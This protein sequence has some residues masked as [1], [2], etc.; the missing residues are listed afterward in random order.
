MKRKI[1]FRAIGIF[2]LIISI[3]VSSVLIFEFASQDRV[4][5][6]ILFLT[7]VGLSLVGIFAI[8]DREV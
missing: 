6:M 1:F 2:I 4:F 3:A 5:E 7:L 8:L